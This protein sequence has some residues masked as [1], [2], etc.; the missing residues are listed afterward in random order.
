[1]Y[2]WIEAAHQLEGS[3]MGLLPQ[4]LKRR[5]NALGVHSLMH[6]MNLM[7]RMGVPGERTQTVVVHRNIPYAAGTQRAHRLD[8]HVPELDRQGPVPV[9]FFVHGGGFTQMSKDTHWQFARAFARRGFIVVS[10]DYPLAP[11]YPYPAAAQSASL[12]L[13]WTL[14]HIEAYGGDL[15]RLVLAGESAGAN[16]V[17][18]LT[19][20]MI[21]Q[22]REP[23]A[24]ALFETGA[25]P[26]AV[27]PMCGLLQVSDPERFVRAGFPWYVTNP[28]REAS[29]AYLP[30]HLSQ[31]TDHDLA[32]PVR[33]F[34]RTQTLERPLPAF[35]I[36]VGSRDPHAKDSFRLTDALTPYGSPVEAKLY[37]G[38]VHSFMA[39][40]WTAKAK[41]FWGDTFA[42]LDE[43]L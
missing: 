7:G 43:V 1:M 40:M 3:E 38:G 15:D 6:A 23:W 11:E 8:V 29:R 31:L 4:W 10:I 28:I 30:E 14:E 26:R 2:D 32:D 35:F 19:L 18:A 25:V 13:R 24:T 16:V 34:E 12:A 20:A 21:T 42:F 17:T 37:D 36:G 5:I 39:F 22:R 41:R 9:V 27:L 33:T